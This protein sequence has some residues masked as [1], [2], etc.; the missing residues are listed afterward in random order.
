MKY[1]I[2]AGLLGFILLLI[3]GCGGGEVAPQKAK[4][5]LVNP[6][7]QKVGEAT[8]EETSHGV[9]IILK[10]ENLPP[11]VHAFHIHEK[12]LCNPPDFKSAGGHFNPFGKKHGLKN[13][14]GPHAGD[15]PNLVVGQD[16]KETIEVIASLVTLKPGKNSLFQPGGTSL[17]VHQGPDDYM[18]D[19]AGNA[20]PRIAC[21][22]ITK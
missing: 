10:V 7:G 12:G 5:T 15:L 4:T 17:V 8:L 2:A 3:C 14:Q 22:T 20:G 6:Q 16:G 13:P 9:K 18:T 11:G 19:P 1:R 21:G